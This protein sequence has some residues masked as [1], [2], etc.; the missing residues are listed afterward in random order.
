MSNSTTSNSTTSNNTTSSSTTSSSS[1]G[2]AVAIGVGVTLAVILVAAI[3]AAVL[4]RKWKI[5]K[6]RAAENSAPLQP[7]FVAAAPPPPAT[8]SS[9]LLMSG[10]PSGDVGLIPSSLLGPRSFTYQQLSIAT[11]G[12]RESEVLG[13]GGFGSVYKGTLPEDGSLVAVKCTSENSRQGV[14]E[15]TAEVNIIS[16]LRHRNL[17]KLRGWCEDKGR[18]LLVYDY[19]PNGSLDHLLFNNSECY[20]LTWSRRY[21]IASGLGLAL[22][23][24]HE[25]CESVIIHRDVKSSNVLLD[26]DFNAKLGDFGLSRQVD[27]GVTSHTTIVAGTRGY[28]APECFGTGK[29]TRESDVYAFGAVL[30]ELVCGKR[31]LDSSLKDH[32]DVLLN[33]VWD[34]FSQD[35]SLQAVDLRLNGSFDAEQV[36]RLV[37]VG[38]LCSHPD[39]KARPS[40]KRAMEALGGT[41]LPSVPTSKPIPSYGPPPPMSV[42][43]ILRDTQSG[44]ATSNSASTLVLPLNFPSCLL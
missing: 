24:L 8:G 23:Y 13:K 19:M 22:Q 15:F 33:W 35:K 6:R 31:A 4:W 39:P 9:P 1:S 43:R 28:M 17:V 40:I 29:A 38:L 32:D 14:K 18:F 25:E 10:Y 44:S 7:P 30:L 41:I 5:K 21:S 16:N 12:F 3:V 34:L 2:S 42:S 27:Q 20:K 36:T 26:Q 11:K 37:R